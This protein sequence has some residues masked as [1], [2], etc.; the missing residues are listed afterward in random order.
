MVR[1][2]RTLEQTDRHHVI[3]FKGDLELLQHYFPDHSPSS[4]IRALVRRF[5]TQAEESLRQH[6]TEV[7]GIT[8]DELRTYLKSASP[9]ESS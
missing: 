4:I 9:G 2:K 1:R 3:L 5:L 8:P 7:K 6:Q